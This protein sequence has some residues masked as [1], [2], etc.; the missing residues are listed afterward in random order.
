MEPISRESIVNATK[1]ISHEY[2]Q[3]T[4]SLK[5]KCCVHPILGV[6]AV[7]P[8]HESAVDS[9]SP[10]L[11]LWTSDEEDGENKIDKKYLCQL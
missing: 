5:S 8:Y 6:N 10:S 7:A 3:C 4:P 1:S 9:S 11:M 2:I